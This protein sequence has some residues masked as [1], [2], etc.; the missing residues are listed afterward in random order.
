MENVKECTNVRSAECVRRADNREDRRSMIIKLLV[1]D[2]IPKV[3]N[4]NSRSNHIGVFNG[5]H[6]G[7]K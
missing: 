3:I 4:K 2:D 6:K 7:A 1:P 5:G